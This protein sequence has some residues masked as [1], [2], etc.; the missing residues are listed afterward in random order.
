MGYVLPDVHL[1]AWGPAQPLFGACREALLPPLLEPPLY[2]FLS[3]MC[4]SG[5]LLYIMLQQY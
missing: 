1:G 2:A 3:N 4:S 5:R